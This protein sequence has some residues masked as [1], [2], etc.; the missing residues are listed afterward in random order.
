[1]HVG[2]GDLLLLASKKS[3]PLLLKSTLLLQIIFLL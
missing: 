2:K 3:M 1:M